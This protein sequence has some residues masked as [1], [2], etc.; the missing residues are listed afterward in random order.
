MMTLIAAMALA[1][2]APAPAPGMP[3][4]Q[5]SGMDMSQMDHSKMDH[6]KMDHSKMARHGDGCC[7]HTADGK[8]DCGMPG[9]GDA[10]SAHQGHSGQ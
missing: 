9:K 8:M 7:K 10:A 1:A 4:G 5:M 6:S 3:A 2:A